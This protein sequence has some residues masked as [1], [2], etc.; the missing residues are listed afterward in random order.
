MAERVLIEA[1]SWKFD[2][3]EKSDEH[4]KEWTEAGVSA[5][6][7]STHTILLEIGFN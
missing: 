2:W 3:K 5:S 7:A 4:H 1:C 6:R